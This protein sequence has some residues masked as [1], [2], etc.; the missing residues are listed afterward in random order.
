MKARALLEAVQIAPTHTISDPVSIHW[1]GVVPIAALLS[2]HVE[3]GVT[4]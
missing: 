3:L 4:V 1:D 2:T